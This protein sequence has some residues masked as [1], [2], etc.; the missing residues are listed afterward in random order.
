M[1]NSLS[2]TSINV[3]YMF[4]PVCGPFNGTSDSP[5]SI[6]WAIFLSIQCAVIPRSGYILYLVDTTSIVKDI[7]VRSAYHIKIIKPKNV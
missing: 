5:T 2:T 3:S 6:T 1:P 4:W 7:L